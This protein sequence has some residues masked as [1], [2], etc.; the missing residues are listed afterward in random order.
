MYDL[1]GISENVIKIP[2]SVDLEKIVRLSEEKVDGFDK[3]TFVTLGRLDNNKNQI[4]LLK[5]CKLL[6][7]KTNNFNIY[8]LGDGEDRKFL[9]EYIDENLLNDNVKILGFKENPYP[10]LKNS[11]ASVLTS[12]S[13]GFSL[14]LAESVILNTPIISTNVGIAKELVDNYSCKTSLA[15]TKMNWLI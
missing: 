10:Y 13:E 15:M 7:N 1:F 11:V 3:A 4:L 9:Q 8:L 14:A 2:N 5:A 12:L 6:K